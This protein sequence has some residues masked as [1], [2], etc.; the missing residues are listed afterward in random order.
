GT[1][2][3]HRCLAD[4]GEGTSAASGTGAPSTPGDATWIH[5]FFPSIF[6]TNPGGDFSA[7]ASASTTVGLEGDYTWTDPAM[8]TDAQGGL[9]TPPSTCGWVVVGDES[10]GTSAKKYEARESLNPAQRPMLTITFTPPSSC[11]VD[12][13]HNGQITP[14]DVATFV[15][16]WFNSLAQGTLAGD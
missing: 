3:L 15:T 14:A 7:T 4:W 12:R 10:G 5:R 1:V 16:D 13:D 6:W 11:P 2:T 8:A 9:N